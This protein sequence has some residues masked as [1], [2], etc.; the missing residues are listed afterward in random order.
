MID[1]TRYTTEHKA[2][3]DDFV[4]RS[5][6]GTFLFC[7]DY[8][9][10]HADRFCDHSLMIWNK[11]ELAAVLPANQDGDTLWSHRGL[12]YGGLLTLG[13]SRA[14][15]VCDVFRL[16]NDYLRSAAFRRVVYKPVPWIY[17][18]IP[19]EE[20][21]YAVFNVCRAHLKVRNI[22]S[23]VCRDNAL[24]WSQLRRRSANKAHRLGIGVEQNNVDYA[25]FWKVLTDNLR[26]THRAS[27]VHTLEEIERLHSAFPQ[28]IRLYTAKLHGEVVAGVLLYVTA[29]T[30]HS[31][32]ISA[33]AEG[34]RTH[35][36]DA[37]FRTI[38]TQDY[39][40]CRYFDFG[41][42]NEDHGRVLNEGLIHQKE[43]FGGRGVC[44]DWYEWTL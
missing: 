44:Y 29:Q 1:I 22:A 10:Y 2:V 13:Q 3:W 30:V 24:K 34:K 41:T 42:S 31:Q 4:L 23:V 38:L 33:S 21:L 7:R 43:G 20:D 15:E 26:T 37:I 28:H 35:A 40:H 39:R 6:Q 11:G 14:A 19:A 12:T 27:P 17:H 9:D 5:K 8:M 16:I 25:A 18:Q 36:V 32:Y